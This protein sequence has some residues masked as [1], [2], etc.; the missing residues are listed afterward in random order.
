MIIGIHNDRTPNIKCHAEF[1][2]SVKSG[3]AIYRIRLG[4][5]VTGGVAAVYF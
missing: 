3:R 5:I 2:P 1:H 4:K